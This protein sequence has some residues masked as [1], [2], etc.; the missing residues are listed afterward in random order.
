MRRIANLKNGLHFLDISFATE[1]TDEGL[2]YFKDKLF[3]LTKLFLN[4]L[5]GITSSGLSEVIHT[6]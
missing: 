3:P 6:C 2:I 4:G 5:T 1:V